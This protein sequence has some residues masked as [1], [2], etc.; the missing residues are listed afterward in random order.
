[1]WH[2]TP[3]KP[4]HQ[5]H[6][7]ATHPQRRCQNHGS[8]TSILH[9]VQNCQ[10]FIV[11]LTPGCYCRRSSLCRLHRLQNSGQY[12]CIWTTYST[13]I[14]CQRRTSSYLQKRRERSNS[15]SREAILNST[16]RDD[17]ISLRGMRHIRASIHCIQAFEKKRMKQQKRSSH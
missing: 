11:A 15:L 4:F 3:P 16:K 6:Q 17:M 12:L 14:S 8:T 9:R 10:I 5:N 1:M 7:V 13:S 2:P